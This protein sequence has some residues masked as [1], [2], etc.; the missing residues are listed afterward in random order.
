ML[1]EYPEAE[2]MYLEREVR[3]ELVVVEDVPDHLVE[4]GEER[5][6]SS[7]SGE[8]HD[9]LRLMGMLQTASHQTVG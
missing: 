7:E 6:E 8:V 1:E 2:R 4:H 3:V 9:M 5:A